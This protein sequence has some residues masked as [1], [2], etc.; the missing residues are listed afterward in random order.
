MVDEKKLTE[1]FQRHADTVYRV[2]LLQMRSREDAEDVVQ[3]TFLKLVEKPVHFVD[4]AHERAWLIVTAS[5][6]CKNQLKYWFRTRRSVLPLEE[7]TSKV[8]EDT[9]EV[10]EAI[11][12]LPERYATLLYLYYYEGYNS[13]EIARMQSVKESTLRSRL[14]KARELM[15]E[16]LRREHHG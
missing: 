9:S 13:S 8:Q 7:V 4:E 5:N 1:L 14:V 11:W 10:L 2:C 15:G 3:S 6:A 12:N 16:K